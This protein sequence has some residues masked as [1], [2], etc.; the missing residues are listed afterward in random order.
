MY[1]RMG[2]GEELWIVA[3]HRI[4]FEYSSEAAVWEPSRDHREPRKSRCGN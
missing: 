4:V 2:N 3:V 1:E